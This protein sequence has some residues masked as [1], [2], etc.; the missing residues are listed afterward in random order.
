MPPIRGWNKPISLIWAGFSNDDH[1]FSAIMD[2]QRARD[3]VEFRLAMLK[4]RG[5]SASFVFATSSDDIGYWAAGQV[6]KRYSIGESLYIQNSMEKEYEKELLKTEIN[7]H[8]INPEKG[9]IVACNN[10]I[11]KSNIFMGIGATFSGNAKANQASELI[12]NKIKNGNLITIDDVK[13]LQRDTH[14]KYADIIIPIIIDIAK[15]NAVKIFSNESKELS[16]IMHLL[17][18]LKAWDKNVD[19][20]SIGALIYNLWIDIIFE[21]LLKNDLDI[22]E[23][24]IVKSY[25]SIESFIGRELLNGN[26][27]N[28]VIF[29]STENP[30]VPLLIKTLLDVHEFILKNIGKNEKNWRWDNYNIQEYYNPVYSNS[31]LSFLFHRKTKAKVKFEMII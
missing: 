1:S 17:D 7:P 20:D 4:M 18:I 22:D 31:W 19:S 10:K 30:N 6:P 24:K 13:N 27:K 9:F 3:K 2:L 28:I 14:D 16:V 21:S 29:Q 26:I 11:S 23:I 15:E 8:I 12:L 25:I 5:F